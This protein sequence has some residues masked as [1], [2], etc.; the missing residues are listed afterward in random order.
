M[1]VRV[2]L[3]EE[4]TE[5]HD[6]RFM[7]SSCVCLHLLIARILIRRWLIDTNPLGDC[8]LCVGC[9]TNMS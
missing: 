7:L 1:S 4:I 9:R 2:C 8:V 3:V 5:I 6:N